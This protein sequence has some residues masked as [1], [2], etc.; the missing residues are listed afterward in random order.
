MF[1]RCIFILLWLSFTT[2]VLWIGYESLVDSGKS[3]GTQTSI[4]ASQNSAQSKKRNEVDTPIS[5]SSTSVVQSVVQP[6]TVVQP[7]KQN[8]AEASTP[9]SAHSVAQSDKPNDTKPS[10]AASSGSVTQSD[11]PNSAKAPTSAA[12]SS[13]A[14]SDKP[15]ETE[16]V[17]LASSESVESVA[18][19]T[20]PNSTETS[21]PASNANIATAIVA[22]EAIPADAED[23]LRAPKYLDIPKNADHFD[24]LYAEN[25]DE[26]TTPFFPSRATTGG[27]TLELDMF[28]KAEVC[29]ACHD[30]IYDEWKDSIMANAWED[31]IYRGLLA[32]ASEATDGKVD[33]LCIG[34][35]TPMGLTTDSVS[36]QGADKV[37]IAGIG[38]DDCHSMSASTG[39]GNG[40]YVL[41]PKK[42]GRSLKFGPR[43]DATS[44]Y[45]DTAY[46]ELHTQSEFCS[47]CHNV[48]H[49]FNRL[50]VERTYDEWRDSPYASAD[51]QCQDCHM[52]PEPGVTKNPGKAAIMG[53]EREHVFSHRFTG[54]NVTLHKHFGQDEMA[55]RALKLLQSAAEMEFLSVPESLQAG[56]SASVGLRV[57]NVGAG[58]K[59]PTGFP[60][61][62]EVWIDLK[63]TDY[64]G[65]EVYRLGA[66]K[67]GH[68]EPGT[69]NFKATL[70]DS[71]GNVVEFAVWEAD[72]VLSDTRILPMGYSDAN[73]E[74][75]IPTDAEGPFTITADLNYWGFAQST[76]DK[77]VG[78]NK[79]KSEIA[80]MATISHVVPVSD[81]QAQTE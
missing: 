32:K 20:S 12:S 54:A 60:E 43:D 24:L 77:I 55:E 49:P 42:Y 31:P 76:L 13:V 39:T 67:D 23:L 51:I 3:S 45:H 56:E 38:C 17:I 11:E 16:N 81:L 41:T 35:H 15:N 14:Q 47:T 36:A 46:S 9:A 58:H 80:K 75:V 52:T 64:T 1:Y 44:P 22:K 2:V 57:T 69:K 65:A 66:V 53:P 37:H 19:S 25:N 28:E 8:I 59:L 63:V 68:T 5:T 74:F 40:S 29:A 21:I 10:T 4:P 71:D 7:K 78:E 73:Y 70:G 34:C 27:K 6:K 79:I 30:T 50:P 33:K 72:R 61:G 62:R 26:T 18:K 48:T